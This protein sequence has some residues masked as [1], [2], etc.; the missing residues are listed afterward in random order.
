MSDVEVLTELASKEWLQ[1]KGLPVIEAKPVDSAAEAIACAQ[2][3]GFP[4]V[5][6]VHSPV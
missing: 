6:K 3:M 2:T 1:Q 4:V 5:L